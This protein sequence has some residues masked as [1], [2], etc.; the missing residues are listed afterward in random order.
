MKRLLHIILFFA[1]AH[2]AAY[3]QIPLDSVFWVEKE[4]SLSSFSIM[5]IKHPKKLLKKIIERIVL[6][7]KQKPKTCK[8]A[9]DATVGEGS[10][11][12][13]TVSCIFSAEAGFDLENARMEKFHYEG[14]L[15]LTRQDTVSI[16]S[17][18]FERAMLSPVRGHRTYFSWKGATSSND[19]VKETIEGL[20]ENN[21]V[22][23]YSISSDSG[24]GVYRISFAPKKTRYSANRTTGTAFFD[25]NTF[26]MTQFKGETHQHTFGYDS[27]LVYQIDYEK[28]G[29]APVVKQ[30]K[31]VGTTSNTVITS[32]MRKLD[33]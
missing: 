33:E 6:D 22:K 5:P 32:I 7:S 15:P 26:R 16:K 14:T 28:K 13:F 11:T 12:S 25:C 2:G 9:I 8:Y 24:K 31:M 29:K 30:I 1:L 19:I 17:L 21:T 23:A 20:E 27:R 10:P 18:L 4:D 3:A